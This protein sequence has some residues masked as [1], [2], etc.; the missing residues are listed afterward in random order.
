MSCPC[1]GC[2]KIGKALI[3]FTKMANTWKF[4]LTFSYKEQFVLMPLEGV[5]CM[6]VGNW[7]Y[8]NNWLRSC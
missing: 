6:K 8:W 5:S 1:Y 2:A 3:S 4:A 7:D